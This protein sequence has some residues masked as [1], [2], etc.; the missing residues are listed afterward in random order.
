MA[1][2]SLLPVTQQW[3]DNNGNPLA[4]GKLYTYS[5]GTT[6]PKATWSD[7][8]LTTPNTN[9]IILDSAGRAPV[10]GTGS[11]KVVIKTTADV[12]LSTQ[13]NITLRVPVSGV[14]TLVA[15]VVVV[16]STVVTATTKIL[17]TYNT[18]AGTPGIIY[19]KT[20]DIINGVSFSINS[21]SLTDTSTVNWWIIDPV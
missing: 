8:G 9:P 2:G 14:A 5:S 7:V 13:D 16:S 21:S 18:L 10:F 4:S 19:T 3:F 17:L 15:G 20:S 11:Y 1:T 12:T 6:T